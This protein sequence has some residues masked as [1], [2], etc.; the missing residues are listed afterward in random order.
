MLTRLKF[1]ARSTLIYSIGSIAIKFIGLIL[2]PVYTDQLTTEQ[3]GIW[4]LIEV[5]SQIFL[6]VFG[7]RLAAAMLRFY[8]SAKN[9]NEKSK[10][11]FA[12]FGAS[13]LSTIVFNLVSQ[14]FTVQ[15]SELIFNTQEFSSYFSLMIIWTSFEIFNRLVLDLIRI[16]EK[17]G[18]YISVV[19]IKFILVLLVIIYLIVFKHKGIE[20]IILGQLA[21]SIVLI[22]ISLP[23]I[24][25]EMKW[26]IDLGVFKEMF[27]YSFPLIFSGMA[28]FFL[29]VGDR[30]LIK[31]FLDNHEVGIYS[32]SN[33]FSNVIKIVFIQAFQLG[34]LP[35]AFTMFGKKGSQRFFSKVFTYFI[36]LLFWTGLA[37]SMFSKEVIL[38]FA[39]DPTYYEAYTYIPILTL[40]VC[41]YGLQ[42]FYLLGLLYARK[43]KLIAL[44]THIVLVI[45]VGLNLLL[46]PRIGLYGAAISYT[47][48]GFALAFADYY[49]SNKSYPIPYEIRKIITI[50]LLTVATYFSSLLLNNSGFWFTIAIKGLLL[51]LFP[52]FLYFLGF[53]EKIEIERII[54]AW[55]KWKKPKY[56]YANLKN[57]SAK[58]SFDITED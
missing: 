41:F 25:K 1:T 49:Y 14:P 8:S 18:L 38:T 19:I 30:Y 15:M 48:S 5:T 23:F 12:A 46:I 35:I 2:L 33:K 39:K 4:S 6:M 50:I 26:D 47:V 9:T 16:K 34:F 20:G 27:K 58:Q 54:G 24:L 32:L 13:F 45:N 17:P 40:G 31:I 57:L 3:Y 44:L 53:Y 42:N 10:V 52:L 37:L 21:G 56:W 7:M 22:L 36:F 11:I 55:E 43:T 51:I 29:T 28:A